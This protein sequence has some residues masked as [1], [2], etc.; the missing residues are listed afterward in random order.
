MYSGSLW[1]SLVSFKKPDGKGL[2]D[3][4]EASGYVFVRGKYR[5]EV[6]F[7]SPQLLSPLRRAAAVEISLVN[8][9]VIVGKFHEKY[10]LEKEVEDFHRRQGTQAKVAPTTE[11]NRTERGRHAR[12]GARVSSQVEVT[13]GKPRK[14]RGNR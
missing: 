10:H 3:W 1:H 7:T 13:T 6:G 9:P 4:N 8:D 2:I 14:N 5:L 12:A 11:L